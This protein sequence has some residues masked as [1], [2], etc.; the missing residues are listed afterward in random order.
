MIRITFPSVFCW[1]KKSDCCHNYFF[2]F[3]FFKTFYRWRF[4]LA[5]TVSKWYLNW[6]WVIW[7]IRLSLWSWSLWIVSWVNLFEVYLYESVFCFST[8][9]EALLWLRSQLPFELTHVTWT[10]LFSNKN[11]NPKSAK[12]KKPIE[13]SIKGY[14]KKVWCWSFVLELV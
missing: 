12:W 9:F 5:S 4:L 8:L 3:L 1:N 6:A 14:W 2:D 11:K 13:P 10:K 7:Q